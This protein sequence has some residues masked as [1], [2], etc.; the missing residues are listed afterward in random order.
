MKHSTKQWLLAA[1]AFTAALVLI[2]ALLRK[3]GP[4]A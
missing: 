4:H 3:R 2:L 1:A